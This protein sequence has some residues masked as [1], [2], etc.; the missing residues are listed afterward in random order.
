[1]KADQND[2]ENLSVL[3]AAAKCNYI[4]GVPQGDDC[5]LMYQS[6][7]YHDMAALREIFGLRPVK[8]FDRWLEKMGFSKDGK[9][10]D[11]AGD[12]SVFLS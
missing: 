3:L 7:A 2:L 5:M 4:I 8:E 6:A 9:L 10:T 12:G 1:M 11:L